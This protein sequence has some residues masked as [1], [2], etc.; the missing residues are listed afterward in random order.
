MA[1]ISTNLAYLALGGREWDRAAE[2]SGEAVRLYR[3]ISDTGG[4]ALSLLNLGLA[5]IHQVHWREAAVTFEESLGLYADLGYKDGIS[6]CLEGLAAVIAF[7]GDD[8]Q[9]AQLLGAAAA[10]RSEIDAS[11]EPPGVTSTTA[12]WRP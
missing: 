10:L 4:I 5:Q 9:A 12:R 2:L 3:E 7:L 11:L 6:Y 8:V 1:G